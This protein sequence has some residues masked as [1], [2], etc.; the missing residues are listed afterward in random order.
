[1]ANSN[2]SKMNHNARIESALEELSTQERINYKKTAEKWEVERT[3]LAKRH[4]GQTGTIQAANSEVRQRLTYMQEETLVGHINRLTLRG[5][6]PTSRIVRNI[7]EEISGQ[8]LGPNW[9]TRF[10]KRHEKQLKSLYLR[11]IDNMRK[12]AD[13]APYFRYLYD[14]VSVKLSANWCLLSCECSFC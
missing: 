5:T 4:K 12:K 14:L 1:M 6:P 13:Y 11:T 7:A 2:T 9:T 8:S 3:T 10:V